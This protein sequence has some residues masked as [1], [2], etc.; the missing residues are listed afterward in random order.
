[1]TIP[2]NEDGINELTGFENGELFDDAEQVL[3]Y[4]TVENMEQMFRETNQVTDQDELDMM[5]AQV[6]RNRWH[7]NPDKIGP[8]SVL[9]C[10]RCSHE[11]RQR[12]DSSPERCPK[13]NS[14]YW[15]RLRIRRK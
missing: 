7:M 5:A 14:P 1:M 13:C 2:K 6:L 9:H 10:I 3:A 11:W 8:G 15:D 4:F 12:G